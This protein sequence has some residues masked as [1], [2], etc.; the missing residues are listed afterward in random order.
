MQDVMDSGQHWIGP[1]M[2]TM[3][4]FF[5]SFR[6]SV[7]PSD[8][9]SMLLDRLSARSFRSTLFSTLN[10]E[11]VLELA[12]CQRG[13]KIDYNEHGQLAAD[14]V[15]VWKLHGSCNFIPD[16]DEITM[17][18]GA[19]YAWGVTMNVGLVPVDP[20][21]AAQWITGDNA[22]YPAMC[23][24]TLNKPSQVS[25]NVFAAYQAAWG[26]HIDAAINVITVGVRPHAPDAHI[27]DPIESTNAHVHFVGSRTAFDQWVRKRGDRPTTFLG[28]RFAD[29]LSEV[30]EVLERDSVS[31]LDAGAD[32]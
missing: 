1:L 7:S 13:L 27:W 17:R 21:Q 23:M 26:R 19:S 8:L 10:Y 6:P 29:V 32:G 16:P 31:F 9:Y 30:A 15:R 5:C 28:E 22:L 11:C 4:L 12:A 20:I 25:P 18:R 3:G 24:F 14:S 2:Q